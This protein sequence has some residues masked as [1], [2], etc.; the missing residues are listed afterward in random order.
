[1][2]IDRNSELEADQSSLSE[3]RARAKWASLMRRLRA[4]SPGDIARMVLTLLVAAAIFG[5]VTAS[6]P[7]LRPF[8][9]GA[10]VV[11]LLLPIVNAL[12]RLMPRALAALCTLAGFIAAVS[13]LGYALTP[14]L[15]AQVERL[16]R[17]TLNPEAISALSARLD[18]RLLELPEPAQ[19]LMRTYLDSMSVAV[20]EQVEAYVG[21]LAAA[22]VTYGLSLVDTLGS[23]IGLV[24]LPLWMLGMMIGQ[25]SAGP[26]LRRALPAW[27]QRDVFALIRIVDRALGTFV[28]GQLAL[29][30]A[31]GATLYI[32]IALLEYYTAFDA[33]YPGLIAVLAA[34]LQLIPQ[35]GPLIGLVLFGFLG[36]GVSPQA[37]LVIVAL[38]AGAQ[39]FVSTFVAPHFQRRL[40]DLNPG[41]LLLLITALS[42][43]GIFWV[44]LSGPLLAIARDLLR[45]AYGRIA[46]PPRPAGLLPGEPLP[47]ADLR[48]GYR[49][50]ARPVR[51]VVP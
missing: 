37:A 29:G 8:A 35:F 21:S 24:L 3:R 12:E 40:T 44:L 18:R 17:T 2:S 50:A 33:R 7:A 25:R 16:Y 46:D 51:R 20:R 23:V 43:F 5:L 10:F 38:Y 1:M 41:L 47:K 39:I 14:M 15:A 13:A 45:Y 6:W 22:S 26:A 48:Y 49:A 30:I 19:S 32:G 42:P 34:L 36:L 27:A 4:V 11:Y 31:V 9:F 28:R